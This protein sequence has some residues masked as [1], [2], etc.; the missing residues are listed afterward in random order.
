VLRKGEP[1]PLAAQKVAPGAIARARGVS[2]QQVGN[3][4]GKT[5]VSTENDFEVTGRGDLL[6]D[7]Q[8]THTHERRV[9]DQ[10]LGRVGLAAD[11][12]R[13]LAAR[14]QVGLGC[15]LSLRDLGQACSDRYTTDTMSIS[16]PTRI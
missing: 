7:L 9:L 3:A 10:Q 13:L 2:L 12:G 5:L 14:D 6:Q 11:R 16:S 8:L 1:I 15:L 4:V